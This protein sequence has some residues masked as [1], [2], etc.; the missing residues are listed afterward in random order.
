MV[1]GPVSRPY[2]RSG[3]PAQTTVRVDGQRVVVRVQAGPGSRGRGGG[4]TPHVTLSITTAHCGSA[5]GWW[6]PPC[7]RDRGGGSHHRQLPAWSLS[8]QVISAPP[9]L[10]KIFNI[11]YSVSILS[12]QLGWQNKT[13]LTLP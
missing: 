5:R 9:W 4:T 12:L 3:A 7:L 10:N 8:L 6:M 2:G 1:G 11:K 13:P